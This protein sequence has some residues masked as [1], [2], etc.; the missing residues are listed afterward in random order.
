MWDK[1]QHH[2]DMKQTDRTFA[3][4]N[5]NA[6]APFSLPYVMMQAN[7][8]TENLKTSISTHLISS[9]IVYQNHQISRV[10]PSSKGL[11]LPNKIW[12]GDC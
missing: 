1:F 8:N 12:E 4:C 6:L 7:L 9:M 3:A 10:K 11:G 2:T 5:Y